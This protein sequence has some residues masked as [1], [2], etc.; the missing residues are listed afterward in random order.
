MSANYEK[1]LEDI[2]VMKDRNANGFE[3]SNVAY[4]MNNGNTKIIIKKKKYELSKHNIDKLKEQIH[5]IEL[6]ISSRLKLFITNRTS[7]DDAELRQLYIEKTDLLNQLETIQNLNTQ[8][9]DRGFVDSAS[10]KSSS[11]KSSSKKSSSPKS[12]SPKSSSKKSSQKMYSKQTPKKLSPKDVKTLKKELLKQFR[13]KT[14]EECL[15]RKRSNVYYTSRED[16]IKVFRE[17]VPELIPLLIPA[18]SK[19]SKSDICKVIFS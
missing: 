13:F 15:S 12:S 11:P 1:Q 17:N 8:F 9:I 2:L 5:M 7:N 3:E 4:T 16:M 18:I 14:G 19:A 10:I 6:L